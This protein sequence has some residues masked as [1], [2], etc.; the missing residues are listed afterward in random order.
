[1]IGFGRGGTVL[2][3]GVRKAVDDEATGRRGGGGGGG[4]S[5]GEGEDED[6]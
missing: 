4:D 2:G 5:E 6:E 1:M 3:L